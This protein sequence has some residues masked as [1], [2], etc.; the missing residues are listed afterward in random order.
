MDHPWRL[1]P[2][3]LEVPRPERLPP[4]DRHRDQILAAHGEA[5]GR[6]AA[7]YRDPISGLSVFTAKFL[8]DRGY[9]CE[10]GCRHCPFESRS[11]SGV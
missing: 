1:R 3:G 8:A 6:G 11:T 7:T 2:N 5:L 4:S 9:C 10:S